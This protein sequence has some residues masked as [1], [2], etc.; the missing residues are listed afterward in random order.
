MGLSQSGSLLV[1]GGGSEESGSSGWNAEAYQWAVNQSGNNKVA[2]ISYS[3]DSQWL[4]DHFV[5]DWGAKQSKLFLINSSAEA[6]SQATYDSLMEYDVIF[7]KGGNQADYYTTYNNTKTEQAI[8]DKFNNGG[9]I[10]GTSAGL[11]VLGGVDFTAENGTVYPYECLSNWDNQYVALKDDFLPLLD[12]F[13]FDS[14]FVQRGRFSRLL[15]FMANWQT[16]KTETLT[17]IGVDDKTALAIDEN[18]FATAYGSGCV[19]IYHTNKSNVLKQNTKKLLIDSL[20]LTQLTDGKSI[21][22]ANM[23]VSG[24]KGELLPS[25]MNENGN[26]T[27]FASGGSN[28]IANNETLLEEFASNTGNKEDS[29][30]ILTGNK[31]DTAKLFEDY[32]N[33][34]GVNNTEVFPAT[35][36]YSDNVALEENLKSADKYLFV[37]ADWNELKKFIGSDNGELLM[38]NLRENESVSAFVGDNSRFAGKSVVVN[39]D[40]PYASYD[41]TYQLNEGL[42]LLKTSVIIPKTFAAEFDANYSQYE[43]TVAAIP[44]AM[45]KDTLAYGIW[46][47]R[48]NYIKFHSDEGYNY[49]E[50]RGEWPVIVLNNKGTR[51]EVV[52]RGVSG[53]D[54]EI[55]MLGGFESMQ[56]S[57]IDS[58]MSYKTG[59]TQEEVVGISPGMSNANAEIYPDYETEEIHINWEQTSYTFNLYNAHGQ[60]IMMREWLNNY[61]VIHYPNLPSGMYIVHLESNT[62]IIVTKKL[63]L[64]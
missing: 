2:V 21:D 19:N 23:E 42:G 17:G 43:N 7:L 57:V 50:A 9:V 10:C 18:K 36:V 41:G 51:G 54:T 44:Y 63:F 28:E 38:E 35:S 60:K 56:I 4:P 59:K 39:Y 58:T 14:H 45:V 12:G 6:T 55:R 29:I 33:S 34:L 11:A 40:E 16:K 49:L 37:K 26:Y 64:H 32:L 15:G 47:T 52:S 62:G 53:P 20:T 1:I 5:S 61:S 48:K 27:I 46:L 25:T 13:I 3:S 24:F 22:L 31:Q 30:L 8:T